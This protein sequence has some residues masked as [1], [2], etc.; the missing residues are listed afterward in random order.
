MLRRHLTDY[1]TTPDRRLF[2]GTRP[3]ANAYAER[4]AGTLRR[5]CLDHVLIPGQ[6]H[7]REILAEFASHCNGHRPHQ[8]PQHESPPSPPAVPPGSS[9]ERSSTG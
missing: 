7:P 4:I 2:R 8:A 5:E 6:R 3:Q 1:P 9:A